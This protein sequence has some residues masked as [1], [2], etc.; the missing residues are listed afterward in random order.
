MKNNSS[1]NWKMVKNNNKKKKIENFNLKWG[2]L[3]SLPTTG[4]KLYCLRI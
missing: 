3:L 4:N 2:V 1:L